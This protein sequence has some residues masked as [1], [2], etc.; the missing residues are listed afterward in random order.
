MRQFLFPRNISIIAVATGLILL[1]LFLFNKFDT[2]KVKSPSGSS[3]EEETVI[4]QG[5]EP[6]E[7]IPVEYERT[8]DF[9]KG[10]FIL[11]WL[12]VAQ[13]EDFLIEPVVIEKEGASDM[14][15]PEAWLRLNSVRIYTTARFENSRATFVAFPPIIEPETWNLE[16]ETVFEQ[17]QNMGIPYEILEDV[18]E[19]QVVLKPLPPLPQTLPAG[20]SVSFGIYGK[21]AN[22]I[23]SRSKENG[24]RFC[25]KEVSG[26]L[27]P[28]GK[29]TKTQFAQ[30][31]CGP[32]LGIR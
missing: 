30:P 28:S 15:M 24:T 13:G 7:I 11:F 29:K 23:A 25:L 21:W 31:L 1:G 32:F 10:K 2:Q 4:L 19:K 14:E 16:P 8:L 17:V 22:D 3:V 6:L 9:G 18:S 27:L 20:S 12:H 26:T 5:I